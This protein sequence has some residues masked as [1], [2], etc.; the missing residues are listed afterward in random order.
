M[1]NRIVVTPLFAL[2]LGIVFEFLFF[3]QALGVNYPLWIGSFIVGTLL[4]FPDRLVSMDRRGKL[5]L[6]G[7]FLFAALIMVRESA[8]L[9]ALNIL[10][11]LG[12]LALGLE[13]VAGRPVRRYALIE[14]ITTVFLPL[15]C[16]PYFFIGMDE[17]VTLGG[18]AERRSK[19]IRV[20]RGIFIALPIVG[21]LIILFSSADLVFRKYV[22]DFISLDF[23]MTTVAYFLRVGF[24][25]GVAFAVCTYIARAAMKHGFS[26]DVSMRTATPSLGSIETNIVLGSVSS[27]FFV[28]LAIQF[29][30]LFGGEGAIAA[31]GFVYAE[32]A[33]KGFFE[34]IAVSLISFFLLLSTECRVMRD[35]ERHNLVFRW[36][37]AILIIETL[38]VMVS[39]F[40]R[41]SLY[42]LAY[43]FTTLR[44]Y[45]HIFI[46]WIGTVF[47]ILGYEVFSREDRPGFAFRILMSMILFLVTV[48][49]LNP[50][51]FIA[52][53]NID[54]LRSTGKID[55]DYLSTLSVDAFPETVKLLDDVTV[56]RLVSIPPAGVE[57][58]NN[59]F[60]FG[61]LN[62]LHTYTWKSRPQH[63]LA[64]AEWPSWHVSRQRWQAIYETRQAEINSVMIE[65]KRAV[66]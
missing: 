19:V 38:L 61:Y 14:Y 43:G 62:L 29:T 45:S 20:L 39:A 24:V 12:L 11:S 9:T 36:L 27:V 34:L 41:L 49:I 63:G 28:F 59:G 26:T 55:F 51:R 31:Q 44:L 30:Y 25:A 15:K 56:E 42:E 32:Y 60:R 18:A 57:S 3:D 66:E 10:A 37:A 17:L 33:R 58:D 8:L 21:I 23:S 65:L 53:E 40:Q 50:D 46:G 7:S 1:L 2:A 22:T 4:L 54:R 48:N 13:S 47:V 6:G 35:G 64:Y 16:F 52:Q 5:F